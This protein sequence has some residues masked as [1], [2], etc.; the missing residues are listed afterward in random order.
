MVSPALPAATGA[1]IRSSERP[2]PEA[3]DGSRT[4]RLLC[5]FAFTIPFSIFIAEV[6]LV[7]TAAAAIADWWRSGRPRPR[8]PLDVPIACFVLSGLVAAFLGLDT[9]QSLWGLRTYLQIVIVYL[10]YAYARG[11]PRAMT[12]VQFFLSGM[13]IAAGY[14]VLMAL[15]P[16]PLPRLFL[17]QMTQSGQLL[18]AIG[19]CLPLMLHRVLWPRAMPVALA[20]TLLALLANLKRGVWLGAF[21]TVLTIGGLVSRRLVVV[22]G[23]ILALLATTVPPVRARIENSVRD[24]LLPGNRYDIWIAAIDVVHR[25]PMGVGRKNGAILRD[26]PNIPQHHKHAHNNLLQITLEGGALGLATFLWWMGSFARLSWRTCRKIPPEDV[27]ARSLAVAVFASFVG[28]HTAGL[29][30]YNF[31]DSEVLEIFFLMMGIGLRLEA[32]SRAV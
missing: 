25:F 29:F 28:F 17:G 26:Y 16:W 5:W 20:V 3:D 19:L 12:L 2:S 11:T 23:L 1:P 22:A 27:A 9:L 14:T 6:V 30:E 4:W 7:A 18:F 8:T 15:S 21:V 13:L 24:L 10:V 31:G 32:D